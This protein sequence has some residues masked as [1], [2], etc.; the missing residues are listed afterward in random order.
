M[1][2]L[3]KR[4]N[5]KVIPGKPMKP[6]VPGTPGRE[7]YWSYTVT[8]TVASSVASSVSS[9]FRARQLPASIVSGSAIEL[10]DLDAA[11]LDAAVTAVSVKPTPVISKPT[12][13]NPTYVPPV[14]APAP[15]VS[16]SIKLADLS[17]IRYY[18]PE[19]RNILDQ[20][21]DDYDA[22]LDKLAPTTPGYIRFK[23]H[24]AQYKLAAAALLQEQIDNDTL[25]R[26]MAYLSHTWGT[27]A[28]IGAWDSG[29]G[30]WFH[31]FVGFSAG[32]YP[33]MIIL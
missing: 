17:T 14:T 30:V 23:D 4:L 12:L 10:L 11:D 9:L 5:V 7:G 1:T 8:N 15:V 33:R 32:N 6:A 16:Q 21:Q 29:S 27:N 3:S 2:T 31:T 25:G 20:I 26:P 28:Y 13:S 22:G 19:L 18:I 24:W